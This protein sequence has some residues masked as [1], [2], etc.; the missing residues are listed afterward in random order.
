MILYRS[1]ASVGN[2]GVAGFLVPW[3]WEVDFGTPAFSHQ[4]WC[5][6]NLLHGLSFLPAASGEKKGERCFRPAAVF[7]FPK[8]LRDLRSLHKSKAK[9][10]FHSLMTLCFST[11]LSKIS[12]VTNQ[13]VIL[14][15]SRSDIQ[16]WFP[17]RNSSFLQQEVLRRVFERESRDL[18][19]GSEC[20]SDDSAVLWQLATHPDGRYHREQSTT[21]RLFEIPKLKSQQF[22]SSPSSWPGLPFQVWELQPLLSICVLVSSKNIQP[23]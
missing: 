7:L 8:I 17:L 23:Q 16:H 21:A 18:T 2:V 22:V 15:W 11:K 4:L 9:Q 6:W 14:Q 13:F 1:Q 12:I 5:N 19:G 20:K 10:A 3:S